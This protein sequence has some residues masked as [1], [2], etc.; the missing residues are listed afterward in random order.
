M[1]SHALPCSPVLSHA[2]ACQ[3][4]AARAFYKSLAN[5]LNK[6]EAAS[7]HMDEVEP[8]TV[9]IDD[10]FRIIITLWEDAPGLNDHSDPLAWRNWRRRVARYLYWAI[11]GGL[12]PGEMDMGMLI[13]CQKM[14]VR[15]PDVSPHLP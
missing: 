6:E 1:L 5:L 2:L 8:D 11:D 9:T 4:D 10:P 15:S 3:V 14:Q 12:H 7:F 13:K